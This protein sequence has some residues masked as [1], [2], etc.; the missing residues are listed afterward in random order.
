MN[1]APRNALITGAGKRVGQA[2]AIALAK[3]GWNVALHHNSTAPDETVEKIKAHGVKFCTIQADLNN[4]AEV[5][6]VLPEA[7][8]ALGEISLLINNASIFEK[9]IFAETDEDIFDRHMNINFKAPFFLSQAFA[10][11]TQNGQIINLSDTRVTDNKTA[12]FAYLHSKKALSNLTKMLAVELGPN[13][14]VNEVCIG[15]TE[16]SD[17]HDQEFL[18]KKVAALPLQ[19]KTS[20]VEICKS[21]LHFTKADYLTGQSIFLDAGENLL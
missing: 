18:N 2:V 17:N 11:Q 13:V 7:N 3:D 15:I 8:S 21:I 14:R 10:Q 1:N 20:L 5:A 4:L 16:L 9:C 19:R 6:R 12:Y